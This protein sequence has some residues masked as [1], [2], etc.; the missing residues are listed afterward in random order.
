MADDLLEVSVDQAE[1]AAEEESDVPAA[2]PTFLEKLVSFLQMLLGCIQQILA[3]V[4]F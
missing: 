1:P 2:A 4:R 3:I